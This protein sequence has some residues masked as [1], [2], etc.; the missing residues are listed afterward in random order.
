MLKLLQSGVSEWLKGTHIK[1]L[2]FNNFFIYGGKVFTVI[3][4]EMA[5]TTEKRRGGWRQIN[6]VH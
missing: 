1:L 3:E 2:F 4:G 6:G 5:T